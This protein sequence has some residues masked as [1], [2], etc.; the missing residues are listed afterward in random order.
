MLEF[1]PTH[2]RVER[3]FGL[4][5]GFP[6]PKESIMLDIRHELMRTAMFA[7]RIAASSNDSNTRSLAGLVV[8]LTNCLQVMEQQQHQTATTM[9]LQG[10]DEDEP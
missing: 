1:Y 4:G 6:T 5:S 2:P 3:V 7:E 9:S 10:I 8:T